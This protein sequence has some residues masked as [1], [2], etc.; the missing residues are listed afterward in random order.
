[1]VGLEGIDRVVK[2]GGRLWA[3]LVS[4]WSLSRMQCSFLQL[5][6]RYWHV[7]SKGIHEGIVTIAGM[8][9]VTVWITIWEGLDEI[10]KPKPDPSALL[11][12]VSP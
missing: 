11:D 1:M 10:H 12:P 4:P 6:Q 5:R 9:M 3:G 7:A 2:G 8:S